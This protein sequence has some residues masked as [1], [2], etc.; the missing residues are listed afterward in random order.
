MRQGN[1]FGK[2]YEIKEDN[3]YTSKIKAPI[4]EPKNRK[5]HLLELCDISKTNRLVT[6][7]RNS[8]ISDEEKEFLIRAAQRH[9]IFNYSKIADYYAHSNKEMQWL[10]EKSALVI[11]D[12]DKAIELG[13]VKLGQEIG[14][15]YNSDYD[16]E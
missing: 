2:D 4:Y 8:N 5:P 12:F 14:N 6:E 15:L 13:Y 10:M 11:I 16:E 7:I 1:L 3:K 9:L